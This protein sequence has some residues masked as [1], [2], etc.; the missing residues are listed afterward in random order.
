MEIKKVA[1]EIF[2]N[3]KSKGFYDKIIVD[4]VIDKE[5]IN[6]GERFMLVTSEL[7]EALE[8]DRENR[9]CNPNIFINNTKGIDHNNPYWIQ[10]FKVNI[11]DTL[12]DEVADAIIRLLDFSVALGID[13]EFYIEQKMKYNSTRERLHGKKY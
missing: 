11:K 1:K 3:A 6:I 7:A 10:E 12:E 9:R 5:K 4:G 8:A 2:E 13:I